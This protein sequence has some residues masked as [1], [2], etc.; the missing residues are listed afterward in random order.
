M[1][2][3]QSSLEPARRCLRGDPG[4]QFAYFGLRLPLGDFVAL[5]GADFFEFVQQSNLNVRPP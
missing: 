2:F 5:G 3:A 4:D 1:G